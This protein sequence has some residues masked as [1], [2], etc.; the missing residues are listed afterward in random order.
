MSGSYRPVEEV[1][2]GCAVA[3]VGAI[4]L[5]ASFRIPEVREL[6]GPRTVPA[7]VSGLLVLGGAAIAVRARAGLAMPATG[8]EHRFLGIVLPAV[9]L[10]LLLVWLWGALGWTLANVVVAP[11][12]FAIFGARGRRE[13]L[14]FPACVIA[15]LYLVFFQLLGLWHGTGGLVQRLGLS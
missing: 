10:A 3:L 13:L 11:I 1:S 8:A 4:F 15:F 2:V 6:V 12:F 5:W 9:G 7:L 14:V